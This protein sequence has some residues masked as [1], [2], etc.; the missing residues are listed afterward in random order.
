M[1]TSRRSDRQ[2]RFAVRFVWMSLIASALAMASWPCWAQNAQS[3]APP[4]GAAAS[5]PTSPAPAAAQPKQPAQAAPAA[6]PGAGTA[7]PAAPPAAQAKQAAPAGAQPAGA[8]A[9]PAEKT[10][11]EEPADAAP[12]GQKPFIT[13]PVVEELNRRRGDIVKVLREGRFDALPQPAFEEYY[14]KYAFPRWTQASS[15]NLL[16]QHRKDLKTE[17]QTG[18]GGGPPHDRLVQLA[19][20]YFSKLADGH[21]HPAVRANAM[22]AIGDLYAREQQDV[23]TLPVPLPAA[24]PVLL[25]AVEAA[26][27]IDAVRVAALVGLKQHAELGVADPQVVNQQIIPAML[28]IAGTKVSPGR[29]VEGHAW[30]RA[31]ACDVLGALRVAG[32]QG[33]VVKALAEIAGDSTAHFMARSAAAAAIGKINYQGVPVDPTQVASQVGKLAADALAQ[34]AQL[35]APDFDALL[36]EKKGGTSSMYGMPGMEGSMDSSMMMEDMYSGMPGMGAPA[37]ADE[38]RKKLE[39]EYSLNLRRRLMQRV[40]AAKVGLQG[41][42]KAAT[43]PQQQGYVNQLTDRLAAV[44]DLCGQPPEAYK[45]LLVRIN[46]E[47]GKVRAVLEK[48]AAATPV[49]AAP[50]AAAP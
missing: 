50:A 22:L 42:T 19:L 10:P 23:K 21:Y 8:Q 33:E 37:S 4:A 40:N 30:M 26:D 31:R 36:R 16:P 20:E 2:G 35:E 18:K 17:L 14:T 28:K 43:N 6:Q 12:A 1:P 7:G 24:I 48:N 11:A 32:Q 45:D 34:E 38:E 25:R 5:Q 39:K 41:I 3:A 49:A 27:Q 47:L 44:Q 13:E 46:E 9:A 29:T 15:Y